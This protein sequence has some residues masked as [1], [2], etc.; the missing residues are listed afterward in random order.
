MICKI[1]EVEFQKKTVRRGYINV[2]DTCSLQHDEVERFLGRQGSS[3]KSASIFVVRENLAH[4][5]RLLQFENRRGP[6]CTL[7][8]GS[9]VNQHIKD[10]KKEEEERI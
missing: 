5:K 2:C 10:G 8:L 7:N 9:T 6:G 4:F 1:C 3:N